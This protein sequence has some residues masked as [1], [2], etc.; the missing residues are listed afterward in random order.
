MNS[1]N[2]AVPTVN[3]RKYPRKAFYK[4]ISILVSGHVDLAEGIEISEGGISLKSNKVLEKSKKIIV[5]FFV[6]YGDFYSIR[7][8]VRNIYG[9]N[10][11]GSSLI[12]VNEA[13][14][15]GLSFDEIPVTLKRQI[16]AFI[17]RI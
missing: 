4:P 12:K 7:A 15:Y 10:N 6:P 14:V 17:A 9:S 5:N 3:R 1:I 16:R 13:P 11:S 2:T 8:T